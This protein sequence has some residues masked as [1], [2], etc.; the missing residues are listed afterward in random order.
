MVEGLIILLIFLMA[1]AFGNK[2][3]TGKQRSGNTSST[4]KL[5]IFYGFAILNYIHHIIRNSILL[6][7]MLMY[8]HI[9]IISYYIIY[10]YSNI[11]VINIF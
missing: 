11:I 10:M 4:I 6:R 8:V 2:R 5:S 1:N 7:N 9:H 3:N